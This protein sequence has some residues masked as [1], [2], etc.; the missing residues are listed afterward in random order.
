MLHGH[1]F[2]APWSKVTVMLLAALFLIRQIWFSNVALETNHQYVFVV[3]L[4]PSSQV[5]AYFRKSGQQ[6]FLP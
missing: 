2:K 6:N 3:F 4:S 1:L 5:I